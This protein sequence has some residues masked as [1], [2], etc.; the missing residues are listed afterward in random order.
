MAAPEIAQTYAGL[1]EVDH[2]FEWLE[3]AYAEGCW[4]GTL[5]V[6]PVFDGLRGDPRFA[7]LLQRA[8]LAD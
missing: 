7:R 2:A 8:G 6:A 1:G 5:K 4:L 3:R